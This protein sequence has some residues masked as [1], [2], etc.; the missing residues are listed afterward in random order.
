MTYIELTCPICEGPFSRPLNYYNQKKK[1][2]Y[3]MHCS[4]KCALKSKTTKRKVVCRQCGSLILKKLSDIKKS[5]NHFC[6][7]SCAATYNNTHKTKGTRISKLEVWLSEKLPKLYPDLKFHFNRKDAIN[8]EL[9]V[10]I[11]SLEL[12]FELNGIFHYEPI[13]GQEQLAKIENNDQRKFQACLENGIE[14]CTVD[15]SKL[16]YFKDSNAQPYL[17]IITD[18][19]NL[20]L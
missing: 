8:S 11:P 2:G 14:L 15:V 7:S 10:Y 16:S 12:A 18:I 6:N 3:T 17:N 4:K 13:F 20:K 5:S 1:A 9:D 19:I